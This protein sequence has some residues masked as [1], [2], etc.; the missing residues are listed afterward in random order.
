MIIKHENLHAS[1]QAPKLHALLLSNDQTPQLHALL[2]SNHQAPTLHA[3]LLRNLEPPQLTPLLLGK[4]Q[5]LPDPGASRVVPPRGVIL[6]VGR[7]R[8]GLCMSN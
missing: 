7:G 3:L 5:L 1:H 4:H 6:R 2:L 8:R